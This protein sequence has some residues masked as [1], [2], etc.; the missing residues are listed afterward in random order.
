MKMKVKIRKYGKLQISLFI[1]KF[2]SF[3]YFFLV[4]RRPVFYT[5]TYYRKGKIINT[6]KEYLNKKI[7]HGKSLNCR[8]TCTTIKINYV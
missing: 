4:H 1:R 3:L 2:N 6:T 5:Y 7:T 8:R